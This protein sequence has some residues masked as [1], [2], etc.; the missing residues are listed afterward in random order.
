MAWIAT[1]AEIGLG[2]ALILGLFT[3][4]ASFLSG[5]LLL[6]FALAMAFGL[7]LKSPLDYSVFSASGGAFLLAVYGRYPCSL[8]SLRRSYRHHSQ[9]E[10]R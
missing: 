9:F 5:I 6:L 8:D 1:V 2:A 3:R 4:V 7:G 10:I